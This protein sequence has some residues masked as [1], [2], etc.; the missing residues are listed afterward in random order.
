VADHTIGLM[1]AALRHLLA[2]DRASRE[3]VR[4]PCG[5]ANSAP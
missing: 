4:P 1:L 3:G 5:A 2:G